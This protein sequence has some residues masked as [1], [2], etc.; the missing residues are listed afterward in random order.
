[1]TKPLSEI[2]RPTKLED[3]VGQK[4]LVGKNGII[5][6]MIANKFLASLIFY[7]YPG[8]GKTSLAMLICHEMKVPFSFFNASVDNKERLTEILALA[9][10]AQD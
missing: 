9:R 5:T 3:F 2:E 1:M 10:N 7:G 8:I 6:K 4:H